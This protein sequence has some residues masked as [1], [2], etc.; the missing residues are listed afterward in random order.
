MEPLQPP[1]PSSRAAPTATE[2]CAP[3]SAAVGHPPPTPSGKPPAAQS[4]VP[5]RTT[6]AASSPSQAPVEL[7]HPNGPSVTSKLRPRLRSVIVG[8]LTLSADPLSPLESPNAGQYGVRRV[9]FSFAPTVA[10]TGH[11]SESD[12]P[13]NTTARS[14]LKSTSAFT[15]NGRSGRS[16]AVRDRMLSPRRPASRADASK[17]STPSR[18]ASSVRGAKDNF[19]L[20]TSPNVADD[21]GWATVLPSHWWHHPEFKTPVPSSRPPTS[22]TRSRST[23]IPASLRGKCLRCLAGGHF[24]ASC[25]ELVR[26]LLCGRLGH[27]AREC[28][29][30]VE[31]QRAAPST[32]API[33]LHPPSLDASD[34]PPL[35]TLQWRG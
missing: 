24:V 33:W 28:R 6:R 22:T 23:S 5:P 2:P 26:C 15:S 35:P 3:E 25:R 13:A 21:D 4:G 30:K 11:H 12:P 31:R 9:R 29:G 20:P 16:S 18:D 32:S 8:S 1:S 7:P 34:F 17:E 10:T 14:C 19:K 27:K